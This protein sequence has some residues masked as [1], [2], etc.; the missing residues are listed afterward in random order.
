MESHVFK[1]EAPSRVLAKELAC[2]LACSKLSSLRHLQVP[3]TQEVPEDVL[4]V[5]EKIWKSS[6]HFSLLFF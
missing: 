3:N 1:A 2:L 4:E 6:H 5:L